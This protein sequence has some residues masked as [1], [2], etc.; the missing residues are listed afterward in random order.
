MTDPEIEAANIFGVEAARHTG[1]CWAALVGSA[2]QGL[3]AAG[4]TKAAAVRLVE[5][6]FAAVHDPDIYYDDE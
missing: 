3:L 6:R 4:I 5:T 1:E 2:Y